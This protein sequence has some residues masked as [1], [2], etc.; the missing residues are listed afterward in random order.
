MLLVILQITA[1]YSLQSSSFQVTSDSV[2]GSNYVDSFISGTQD[3]NKTPH[4]ASSK[5]LVPRLPTKCTQPLCLILT[6][7]YHSQR[8]YRMKLNKGRKFYFFNYYNPQI[9]YFS[10]APPKTIKILTVF[11]SPHLSAPS[12]NLSCWEFRVKMMYFTFL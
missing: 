5:A 2:K 10:C 11:M 7:Y 6:V 9:I 4:C 1:S 12:F 3:V 8:Y